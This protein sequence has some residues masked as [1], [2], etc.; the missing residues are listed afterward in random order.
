MN[1]QRERIIVAAITCI[2][3]KGIEGTSM[4]DIWKEAG[5]SAGALYVHFKN[6]EDLVVQCLRFELA[7]D[8]GP[9]ATW[10]ELKARMLN[11]NPRR[12]LDAAVIT[13]A[14]I[15]LRAG[16][17]NPG[18]LHDV[19]RRFLTEQID[20]VAAWL[21]QMAGVG[22][23]NLRMDAHQ[24]AAAICAHIDGMLWIALARD[25]SLD[26]DLT[27]ISAGLDYLVSLPRPVASA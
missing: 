7:P 25:R 22:L 21:D 14:R 26:K 23:L 2:A 3:R 20:D 4:A 13:R 8:C 19:M 12:G 15:H 16:C 18:E 5:L 17:I 1:A 11:F 10:D 6:K 9:P 27:E 24:T